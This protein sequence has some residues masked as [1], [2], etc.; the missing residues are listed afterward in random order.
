MTAE[1][2]D[3]Q[4]VGVMHVRQE[5]MIN[6]PPDRV[7]GAITRDIAAWWGP[8]EIID[9]D[10]ARDVILEPQL[11][12]RLFEDWGNGEGA[13]WG[14]VTRIKRGAYLELTGRLGTKRAV[15]GVI[16]FILEAKG[17]GTLL[18]LSHRA[19]GEIRPETEGNYD[20][21]WRDLLD[22]RLRAFVERG[23][24]LGLRR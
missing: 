10:R 3:E 6:A 2:K 24:R 9:V 20:R 13:I 7:F 17:E 1:T 15:V 12:G 4:T 14:T 22:R 18:R 19:V 16:T 21:G 5:V 23:E 8:P 11:G